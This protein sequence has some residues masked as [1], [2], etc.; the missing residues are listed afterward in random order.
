MRAVARNPRRLAIAAGAAANCNI[1]RRFANLGAHFIDGI[2]HARAAPNRRVAVSLQPGSESVA[3]FV[4]SSSRSTC[5]VRTSV[6]K[7]PTERL[8]AEL[9]ASGPPDPHRPPLDDHG[10]S[11]SRAV[12]V[13]RLFHEH[14]QAL[15]GFLLTRVN[16]EQEA[17]DVAQEAYVRMLELDTPGA[18]GFLRAYLFKTAANL[19]VDRARQRAIQARLHE[20]WLVP[21]DALSEVPSPEGVAS[22]RQE[23][24]LL[25][26]FMAELPP[27]CRAAFY[28]HRFRDLSVLQ[29]AR[30]LGVT[31][32]MVRKYLVQAFVYCRQR[33][34]EARGKAAAGTMEKS[35]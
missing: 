18:V 21:L 19:A 27:R 26:S 28:L 5:P 23:L 3:S 35:S 13:S 11:E 22:A 8:T 12:L 6:L 2:S 16:S 9:P 34:N 31:D 20:H 33:L 32:R 14:N 29:I 10:D 15:I 30:E 7:R 17:R 24:E 1:A 25:R 4:Y